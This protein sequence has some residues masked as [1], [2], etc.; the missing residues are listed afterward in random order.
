MNFLA[1]AYLSFNDPGILVGNMISDF[2]KG[3]KKLDYPSRIQQGI[4]LHRCI[5]E[6]TDTHKATVEGKQLF[7]PAYRLYAG[8]I[9]DVVYDHFL[10]AD[11]AEFSD[12]LL[13][14][15]SQKVYGTLDAN[16]QWLPAKFAA[17]FPYMK[18][19]NWLY[20]YRQREGAHRSL[21]GL[22]HRAT[23]LS[24]SSAAVAV[25]EQHYDELK[26]F[27]REFWADVKP[28]AKELLE[29]L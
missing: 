18:S 15:F 22:V 16:Q 21:G 8:A 19:H 7:R 12:E 27:Y 13:K 25:L 6:F 2:V 11:E 24:D 28:F 26:S 14:K 29:S 4:Y 3:R 20:G 23:Y 5:D 1:H 17:M 9:M 10:A